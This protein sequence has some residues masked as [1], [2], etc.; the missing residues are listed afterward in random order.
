MRV[1]EYMN[2][3]VIT[4]TRDTSIQEASK[5]M[6]DRG[7]RRLPVVEDG[8]LIGIITKDRIGKVTASPITSPSAW[9]L[10]YVLMKMTVGDAMERNL[11]TIKPNT[12]VEEAVAIGQEHDVGA[13]PVI[14]S[15]NCL[16]GIVTA[17]DLY[18]ITCEAIGFFRNGLRL[19]IYE[20]SKAG[21][22]FG[23]VFDIINSQGIKIH[24]LFHILPPGIGREDCIIHLDTEDASE[25]LDELKVCGYDAEVRPS[26]N[27]RLNGMLAR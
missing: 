27:A 22:P 13:L 14:D 12:T 4:V 11:V 21:R 17:T 8:K 1:K 19:H 2:T 5:L 18:K 20:C 25:I 26:Q 16:V 23:E 3:N 10:R 7:I 15:D 9:E 6:E 24:S